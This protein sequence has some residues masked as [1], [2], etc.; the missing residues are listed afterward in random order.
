MFERIFQPT[1]SH[2]LNI[3]LKVTLS[4]NLPL[5]KKSFIIFFSMKINKR[6][7]NAEKYYSIFNVIFIRKMDF[8][9]LIIKNNNK[10]DWVLQ[11]HELRKLSLKTEDA[12]FFRFDPYSSIVIYSKDGGLNTTPGL[13][14]RITLLTTVIEY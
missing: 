13:R 1:I 14:R 5:R 3:R 6:W 10:N 9:L 11:S 12:P 2:E 8:L 7:W 4:Q